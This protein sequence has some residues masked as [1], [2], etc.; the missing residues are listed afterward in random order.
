MNRYL[1][2]LAGVAATATATGVVACANADPGTDA[3]AAP[4]GPPQLGA[5]CAENFDGALTALPKEV[6]DPPNRKNLLECADGQWQTFRGEYS[7]SDRWLSAGTEL[8]LR[9]QGM[10]NPE[11]MAGQWTGTPQEPDGTC[12]V[13]YT[14]VFSGKA[15]DPRI[16]N[17]EAGQ[18]LSFDAPQNLLNIALSGHCLWQREG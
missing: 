9:G 12:G 1:L 14:E 8:V 13:E 15:S 3:S 16:V 5:A 7:T 11:V 10:R 2:A 18:P 4:T 6:G 17:G